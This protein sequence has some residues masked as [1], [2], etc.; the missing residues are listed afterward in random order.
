[1][2]SLNHLNVWLGNIAIRTMYYE[3]RNMCSDGIAELCYNMGID[4]RFGCGIELAP[5]AT[6]RIQVDLGGALWVR[7]R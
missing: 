4:L 5:G 2:K 6:W 3:N 7:F 1:M